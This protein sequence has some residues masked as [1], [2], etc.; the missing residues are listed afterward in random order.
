MLKAADAL[1]CAGYD[2]RVISAAHTS[3]M[4]AVDTE[5][6]ATRRWRWRAVHYDRNT[7]RSRWLRT[8]LRSR[9]FRS[10]AAR[11]AGDVS[12]D[13]AA[14]AIGRIHAELVE[15]ILE[16][17]ADLIYGGA[18]GALA[19]TALAGRRAGVPYALDFEDFHCEE[20][21][22]AGDGALFN[23]LARRIMIEASRGAAFV[24]AGSAAIAEATRAQ[25]GIA[26]TPIHNVFPLPPAPPASRR[27]IAAPLR[28]YWF[29]QTIGPQR[30]IED[31]VKALG[32]VGVPA[33]LHLRGVI[34]PAYAAELAA[35]IAAEAP[36]VALTLLDLLPPDQMLDVCRDY[37]IGISAEQG[38]P[39]NRALNLANK[40]TTYILAGLPVALTDTA[41]QRPLGGDLGAGA[42]MFAPGDAQA[43]AAGIDRLQRT[44]GAYAAAREAS[45]RAARERWHWEHPL[46]RGALLDAVSGALN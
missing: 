12:F 34:A 21:D 15:A 42:I 40:A 11:K 38:H 44:R 45:W 25:L 5:L 37:D 9:L 18:I 10:I 31:V 4:T 14:A 13:V 39:G 30:G 43:L 33:E 1:S 16:E 20:H 32:L 24:T 3:R 41:G 19:A 46:E 29:S 6:H 7:A 2:V 26:A 23:V 36:A 27:E 8:A 17:P 35:R 22:D 28:L